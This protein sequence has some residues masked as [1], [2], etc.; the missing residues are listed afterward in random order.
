MNNRIFFGQL[1][2]IFPDFQRYII[3]FSPI[4]FNNRPLFFYYV[5]NFFLSI[6][7]ENTKG[8]VLEKTQILFSSFNH[9]SIRMWPRFSII[10]LFIVLFLHTTKK[11]L[12]HKIYWMENLKKNVHSKKFSFFCSFQ[13]IN[14]KWMALLLDNIHQILSCIICVLLYL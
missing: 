9:S 12:A 2:K 8:I 7:K 6:K 1:I 14:I 5:D 11:N 10:F 13:T 3:G 4:K